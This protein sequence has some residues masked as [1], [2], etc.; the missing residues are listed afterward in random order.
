MLIGVWLVN[1]FPFVM[2]P[3][4]YDARN[5]QPVVAM[6]ASVSQTTAA[7]PQY[8]GLILIFY[9]YV[10]SSQVFYRGSLF[11]FTKF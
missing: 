8:S 4:C 7:Q 1:H 3:D 6:F 10:L 2:T 5:G 11:F 9:F